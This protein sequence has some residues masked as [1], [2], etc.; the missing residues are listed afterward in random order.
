LI[1]DRQ[2]VALKRWN[3]KRR[4]VRRCGGYTEPLRVNGPCRVT[5][6]TFL[7]R[8]VSFNGMAIRGGGRVTIGDNFHSGPECMILT[9]NH[10]YEGESIPYD[11]T[12][13]D[14]DVVIGDNVWLGI[15]VIVLPGVTI[16]E[17]AIIQAGSV[18]VGDIPKYA[19]AG[20]H[21]CRVFGQRNA[22]HYER[23]KR[24]GRFH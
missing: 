2:I 24:E 7:G 17:G 5:P 18:V 10:H 1:F 19:I 12:Y 6:R 15:R 8:N 11:E 3:Y 20:G 14:R 21:P 4:V 9:R 16:G 22:E 23:L 13:V